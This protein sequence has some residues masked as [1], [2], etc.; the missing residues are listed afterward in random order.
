[1]KTAIFVDGNVKNNV[2]S[3]KTALFMDGNA[4]QP[5]NPLLGYPAVNIP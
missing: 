3:I 5:D 2:P 4:K 1:M